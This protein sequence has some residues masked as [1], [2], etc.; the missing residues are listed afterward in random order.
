MELR[1]I[2][3]YWETR[4]E[5]VSALKEGATSSLM[6]VPEV[7]TEVPEGAIAVDVEEASHDEPRATG[8]APAAAST[9]SPVLPLSRYAQATQA[10]LASLGAP[11]DFE[12]LQAFKLHLQEEYRGFRRDQMQRIH[13]F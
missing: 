11:P 2:E 9:S 7:K 1:Q 8:Y 10:A 3:R 12:P 6:A 13:D 4:V 5:L